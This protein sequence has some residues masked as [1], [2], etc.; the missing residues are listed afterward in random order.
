MQKSKCSSIS[1]VADAEDIG[2]A[3]AVDLRDYD[4]ALI[5]IP[6]DSSITSLTWYASYDGITYSPLKD[7]SDEAVTQT[8]TAGSAI[9]IHPSCNVAP[10]LK[11]VGDAADTINVCIKR[12][13]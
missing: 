8:V 1:V 11:A 4:G 13:G 5:F 7:S 2:D 10:L 3:T 12:L 9:H 6:S